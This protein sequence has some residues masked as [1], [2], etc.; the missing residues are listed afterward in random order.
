MT[1]WESEQPPPPPPPTPPKKI[2]FDRQKL[3]YKY[4]IRSQDGK[5][6]KW[7]Q[8]GNLVVHVDNDAAKVTVADTWEPND[9]ARQL[10]VER[11]T[12]EDQEEA[13]EDVNEGAGAD[14]EPAAVPTPI[15]AEADVVSV[16]FKL[17]K[18]LKFGTVLRIA[19]GCDGLGNW[20]LNDALTLDWTEGNIWVGTALIPKGCVSPGLLVCHCCCAEKREG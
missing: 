15:A 4:I 5:Y 8:G 6:E 20:S 2:T 19:G 9:R 14:P 1:I 10:H 11:R 12:G 3:E 7:Q 13:I 16:T 18:D 17:K